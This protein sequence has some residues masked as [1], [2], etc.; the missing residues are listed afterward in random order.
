MTARLLGSFLAFGLLLA[1]RPGPASAAPERDGQ[2]DFD[3]ELGSWKMHLAR[4][5]EP[6]TG[7]NRW[8][9]YDG[10][11]VVR[12]VWDG[13]ANLGEI[14]LTGP[15][16]RIEGLSLR[17]YNPTSRQWSIHFANR[18]AGTLGDAMVG[19]FANGRG[20]FYN[21]E[22]F[23][24]RAILVRFIFSDITPRSFRLEQAF[25]PD[26]GKTWEPNWVATFTR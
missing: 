10:A 13:A 25:S 8:V 14:D 6:L 17:V 24:G 21:Q 19:G 5:L 15:A 20:E 1:W 4:R 16:G 12:K 22:D 2:R 7:S 3:F 11:S 18:K 26:G 9:E 23:D